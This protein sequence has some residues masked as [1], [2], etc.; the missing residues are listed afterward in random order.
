[1][2]KAILFYQDWGTFFPMTLV[3]CGFK[4]YKKLI[5]YMK[6]KRSYHCEW[7]TALENKP[8]EFEHNHFSKWKHN[9]KSYSLLWLKSWKPNQYHY[10]IL[11][12]ELV[13]AI[14]FYMPDFLNPQDENEAFAYQHSYLFENIADNLNKGLKQK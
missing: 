13:H 9:K 8:E 12:H 10:K 1:M 14:S 6:K 4:D 7:I 2:K 11:A 3:A 5:K